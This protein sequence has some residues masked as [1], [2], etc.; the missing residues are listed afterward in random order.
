ML[1]STTIINATLSI[2]THGTMA[3]DTVMLSVIMQN[4]TYILVMLSVVMLFS[5]TIINATL[6]ITTHSTMALDTVMFSVIMQNVTDI[7]V[8]LSVVMLNVIMPSAVGPML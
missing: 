3:L 6:S 7:P 2:T 1:F 4:V 5:T 8:M